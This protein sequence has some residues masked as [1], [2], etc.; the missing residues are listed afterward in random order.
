MCADAVLANS[1]NVATLPEGRRMECLPS[2]HLEASSKLSAHRS[3]RFSP[4]TL[5][6][7]VIFKCMKVETSEKFETER[8]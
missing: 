7:E 3:I 8:E 5:K 4:A 6:K 1:T 2:F